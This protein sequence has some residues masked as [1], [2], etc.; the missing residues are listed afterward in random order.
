[1]M[2][3]KMN[4]VQIPFEIIYC[5]ENLFISF[6]YSLSNLIY[7][8]FEKYFFLT[9]FINIEEI[10]NKIIIRDIMIIFM[11]KKYPNNNLTVIV[12]KVIITDAYA[13][14]LLSNIDRI[15]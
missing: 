12:I 9:I 7:L 8:L 4:N 15:V 6:L 10:K 11:S 13:K 3:F 5:K 1:M 2:S 14:N